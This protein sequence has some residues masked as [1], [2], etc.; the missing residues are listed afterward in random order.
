MQPQTDGANSIT[1]ES[2]AAAALY[3]EGVELLIRSSPD[4]RKQLLDAVTADADLAVALAAVAVDARSRGFENECDQ[5]IERAVTAAHGITRRERQHVEIVALVLTGHVDRARALC[6]AH[7][8][9]FRHDA[10]IA[11]LLEPLEPT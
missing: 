8:A 7:L 6:A 2:A 10:L 11:H 5:A 4:A 1:T 3:T 9:E